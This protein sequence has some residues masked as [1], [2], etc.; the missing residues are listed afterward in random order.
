MDIWTKWSI[1][2]Q[3]INKQHQKEQGEHTPKGKTEHLFIK[4]WMYCT[5]TVLIYV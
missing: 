4:L 2:Q 1:K 3:C 5:F